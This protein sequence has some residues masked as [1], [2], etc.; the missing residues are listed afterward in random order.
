MK[1]ITVSSMVST[2]LDPMLSGAHAIEIDDKP[3]AQGGFGI[4]YR[5][6]RIDGRSVTPQVIK[7][8]L[9]DSQG[10]ASRG[11]ATIQELQK[12]LSQKNTELLQTGTSL[13]GR[14]PALQAAPQLS[15]EGFFEGRHVAGYSANDLTQ[16]GFEEFGRLLEDGQKVKQ[17]QALPH[18]L[19]MR[20][21]AQLVNAFDL[22]SAHLRFIHAD[23]KAEALFIDLKNVRLA[24][25][26]FDSGALA[27]DPCDTPTTFGTKQDWLAP[28][29]VRQLDDPRN[30]SRSVKVDLLSDVWSV[31]I[32]IHYLFF[33]VHPLFFLTEISTRS[34]EEYFRR[35]QWPDVDQN[36]H[37]FRREYASAYSGYARFLKTEL[38]HEVV[39]RF[40]FTINKGYHDPSARTTYGQWKTVLQTINRPAIHRFAAD[41]TFVS[42]GRPVHLSWEVTGASRLE[43]DGIGNVAN[44]SSMDVPVRQDTVF[45]LVLTPES[46]SAISENVRIEVD[47]QPPKI[48]FF[49]S[50]ETLLKKATPVRVS[51]KVTGA[52][53][54]EIDH[55][56]GD[57]SGRTFVDVLPKSETVFKLTATTLFGVSATATVRVQVS[58]APPAIV[59]FQSDRN[60]LGDGRPVNLSWEVSDE[61]HHVL[62]SGIGPVSRKGTLSIF[63]KC[64][65]AYV[66]TATSYFGH[67][68]S[69]SLR[70]A[71]SKAPPV[72]ERFTAWPPVV[73]KGMEAVVTWKV[74]GAESVRIEP[75]FGRVPAEG[76]RTIRVDK[77]EQFTLKATTYFGVVTSRSVG[78]R[79]LK[80]TVLG[81]SSQSKT[82]QTT[83]NTAHTDLSASR[84]T[85]PHTGTNLV[86]PSATSRPYSKGK[87]LI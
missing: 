36:F 9:E 15:F 6:R 42:D 49:H 57:V 2:G 4:V 71:V 24:I 81:V 72:I 44:F 84:S 66:L 83:L 87:T 3:F 68:S 7:L 77:E 1:S 52:E 34:I 40:A 32:A 53:Q 22:L 67:S 55:G 48:H 26:D 46:G 76:Q 11:F 58:T 41:R 35:F 59:F 13:L 20:L 29:I 47:K 86:P 73:Q 80:V 17:F 38:P 61:A 51:W 85:L 39:R 62:I 18:V 23:I 33:C 28:E 5:A 16:F 14:Y 21:A 30:R 12:R 82:L 79:L 31:N 25:I 8:F 50:A 10:L 74:Y 64:D 75:R 54:L 70:V 65:T 63:Q 60:L 37:Y 45:R 43:I 56:V 78:I 69:T 19:K 27:R